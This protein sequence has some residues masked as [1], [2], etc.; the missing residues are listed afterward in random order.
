MYR[1]F[2][3]KNKLTIRFLT[4]NAGRF[5][6]LGK[7]IFSLELTVFRATILDVSWAK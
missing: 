5:K 3:N 4:R 6:L 2:T 7:I 1:S